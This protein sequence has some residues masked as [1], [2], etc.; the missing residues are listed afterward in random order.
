VTNFCAYLYA[1]LK[2]RAAKGGSVCYPDENGRSAAA[3]VCTLP[4]YTQIDVKKFQSG[5]PDVF[6]QLGSI[7]AGL[8]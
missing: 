3:S 7:D 8:R 6:V 2:R 1:R 5:A 4:L